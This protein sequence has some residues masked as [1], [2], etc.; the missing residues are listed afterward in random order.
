M[1]ALLLAPTASAA[2]RTEILRATIYGGA[3][4]SS[5]SAKKERSGNFT[6]T[7]KPSGAGGWSIKGDEIVWFRGRDFVGNTQA[8]E[9]TTRT[10]RGS[11]VS[12][13]LKYHSGYGKI[14][15]YYKMAI[16]YD[17]AN[18]YEWVN[19]EVSWTP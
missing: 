12:G 9:A 17:N 6:F 18:P 14:G 13:S 15:D 11:I 3:D 2:T 8:T 1:V 16:Q 4:V 7:V 10:Y 19:L 5:Y